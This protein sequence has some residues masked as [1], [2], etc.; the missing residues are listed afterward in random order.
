MAFG[1]VTLRSRAARQRAEEALQQS[2]SY[3]AEAQRWTHTGSWALDLTS[4]KYV[5][6][7]EED[8]RIWGFDQQP[9]PPTSDAVFLRIHPEDRDTWK[10]NFERALHEKVDSFDEYRIVLPDGTVK[11]VHTIRHPVLNSAGDVVKLVGTSIDI[12]ERK[13]AEEA[14]RESE[15]RF[16][17]FVDHAADALFIFDFEQRTIV[18]VNRQAC[19]SLGYTR[20]ELIGTTALA[21]HLDSDTTAMESVAERAAAG[22]T[23]IDTHWHRRKEGTLFPVEAHTS[24]FWYGGRRFLL[25][26]FPRRNGNRI[27]EISPALG[28]IKFRIVGSTYQ[29]RVGRQLATLEVVV[30]APP[31]AIVGVI[32]GLAGQQAHGPDVSP[33][34]G[35]NLDGGE[36]GLVAVVAGKLQMQ[37]PIG[38]RR[39]VGEYLDVGGAAGSGI[40][41]DIEAGQQRIAVGAHGHQTAAFSARP[42]GL[43]AINR[44]R[45]VQAQFVDALFQR[46]RIAK[47]S[48]SAGAVEIRVLRAPDVLDGAFHCRAAIEPGIGVPQLA[49]MVNKAA[50]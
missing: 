37:Q 33:E 22:E 38:G 19:E 50:A 11:H 48:L 6:V 20:D 23:V 10:E 27:G 18:D 41:H 15:T 34:S 4:E 21:F 46:N 7:S 42:G 14:L 49:R 2:E 5:Y 47:L 30:R 12:T 1:I 43:R 13:H 3:L 8:L 45:K 32:G 16:R 31:V 29:G 44:L 26:M 17:T 24:E 28:F 36:G 35:Q 39:H 40:G 25:F 9:G